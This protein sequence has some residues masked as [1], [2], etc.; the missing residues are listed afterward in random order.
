M[1]SPPPQPP[2]PKPMNPTPGTTIDTSPE[3]L[4]LSATSQSDDSGDQ[5]AA[6]FRSPSGSFVRRTVERT[7]EKLSWSGSRLP[8]TS[9]FEDNKG[10]TPRRL[11][12]LSRKT[13]DHEQGTGHN[14]V[15]G[16]D[17]WL[18]YRV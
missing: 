4:G 7:I 12:S 18:F 16:E 8:T 14:S 5:S 17:S 1:A 6:V 2:L 9:K 11:F 13:K 10:S 3:T 15:G